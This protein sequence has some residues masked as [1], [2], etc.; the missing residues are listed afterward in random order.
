[1]LLPFHLRSEL[2]L[3]VVLAVVKVTPNAA[4]RLGPRR[5]VAV[6]MSFLRGRVPFRRVMLSRIAGRG[7]CMYLHGV[8]AVVSVRMRMRGGGVVVLMSTASRL[9]RCLVVGVGS[10]HIPDILRSRGGGGVV[11]CHSSLLPSR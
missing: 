4:L 8:V 3:L 9:G 7:V 6:R 5:V 1:M 11:F 10:L 2:G